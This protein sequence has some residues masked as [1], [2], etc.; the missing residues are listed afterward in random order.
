MVTRG[1]NKHCWSHG[2]LRCILRLGVV[3]NLSDILQEDQ[4]TLNKMDIGDI[5]RGISKITDIDWQ[6]L[7]TINPR[8]L[9]DNQGDGIKPITYATWVMSEDSS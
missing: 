4:T 2:L 1:N 3:E 6:Y 8:N 9:G 7:S 5:D